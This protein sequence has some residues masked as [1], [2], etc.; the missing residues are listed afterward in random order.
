MATTLQG[1]P[2]RRDGWGRLDEAIAILQAADSLAALQVAAALISYR[3]NGGSLPAL[4]G[5]K[6]RRGS[7]LGLPARRQQRQRRDE[8]IRALAETLPGTR[9]DKAVAL[10]EMLRQRD[11]RTAV[12][13]ELCPNA[14]TSKAQL[15][16]IL[17]EAPGR[18]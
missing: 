18:T 10:A 5:I 11:Q 4:L 12:F 6:R 15:V 17:R 13:R 2:P 3:D 1:A 14:P 8:Q 16:R 9:T 7:G